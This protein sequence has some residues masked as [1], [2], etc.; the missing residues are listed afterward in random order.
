MKTELGWVQAPALLEHPGA[1]TA[2]VLSRTTYVIA[3]VPSRPT[4][5]SVT[6]HIY[7]VKRSVRTRYSV[8]TDT[9]LIVRSFVHRMIVES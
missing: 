8:G 1:V 6:L 4:F 2:A 7:F 9:S 3:D 5:R